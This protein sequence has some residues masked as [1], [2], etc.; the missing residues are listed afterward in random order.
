MPL[1]PL[2]IPGIGFSRDLQIIVTNLQNLHF[3]DSS[4]L[5][6]V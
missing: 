5:K 4:L 6:K 3:F 1:V 2:T